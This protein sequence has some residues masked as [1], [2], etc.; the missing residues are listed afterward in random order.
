MR[1]F[2]AFVAA[3]FLL[4]RP[5]L[6]HDYH[7]HG[8]DSSLKSPCIPANSRC[9]GAPGVQRFLWHSCCSGICIEDRQKGLGHWCVDL[10]DAADT[11]LPATTTVAHAASSG[12]AS[13]SVTLAAPCGA[14]CTPVNSRCAGAPGMPRIPW[15]GCC[16]GVCIEDIQQG[17]GRWCVDVP[18]AP[19]TSL[20]VTSLVAQTASSGTTSPPLTT[21]APRGAKCTPVNG[22][23]AGAPGLPRIPWLGC[24]NGICIVDKRRG[25]GRW[26]IEQAGPIANPGQATTR[27]SSTSTR[28]IDSTA[29]PTR[30]RTSTVTSQRCLSQAVH[31]PQR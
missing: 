7:A 20:P 16:S 23:C 8:Y 25:W 17:W 4:Q 28:S 29:R 15:L 30:T 5:V 31:R 6:A 11:S 3:A 13:S 2:I 1:L 9:E 22:R 10:P 12:T 24:C 27:A 18:A 19:G 26:C 21:V 14:K